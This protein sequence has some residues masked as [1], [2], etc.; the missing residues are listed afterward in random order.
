MVE[1]GL[2]LQQKA[3]A[4]TQVRNLLGTRYALINMTVDRR[5]HTRSQG[6]C[7]SSPSNTGLTFYSYS[8]G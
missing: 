8:N 5:G 2:D 4:D 1:A 7:T 6:C 3:L